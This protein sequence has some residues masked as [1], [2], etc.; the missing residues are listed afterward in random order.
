M[1]MKKILFFGLMLL[2][3]NAASAQSARLLAD[4]IVAIVGDK[5]V[6]RSDLVNYIEDMK[7]GGNDVPE[8]ADCFILERMMQDKALILQA[9]K[10]SLP[11]SDEEVEAELDQRIRYF[12]MQYGGKEAFEQI[13]GRTIYQVKEDFRKSSFTW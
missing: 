8:N 7:R 1:F 13:A 12:I 2:A 4:K 11:V 5:I 10:D 9:E 3:V 6:L